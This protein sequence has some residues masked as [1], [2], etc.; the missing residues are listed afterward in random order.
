MKRKIE[1][2]GEYKYWM[3]EDG[4]RMLQKSNGDS[5]GQSDM[6]NLVPWHLSIDSFITIKLLKQHIC[7]LH[8]NKYLIII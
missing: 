8:Y 6:E 1:E 3:G 7:N 4:Y 2:G 5:T